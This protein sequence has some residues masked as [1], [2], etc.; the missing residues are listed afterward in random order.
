METDYE[1]YS[2]VVSCFGD[3]INVHT[4]TLYFLVRDRNWGDE[5]KEKVQELLY[6]INSEWGLDIDSLE[7]T[8]HEN[9]D[10]FTGQIP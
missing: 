6:K 4:E 9:C 8:R 10:K 5:N 7:R 3:E 1:N 2:L